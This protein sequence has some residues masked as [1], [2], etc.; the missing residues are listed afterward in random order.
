MIFAVRLDTFPKEAETKVFYVG[1]N[2]PAELTTTR[3]HILAHFADL[4]IEGEYLHRVAFNIAEK[5]GKDAFLSI[6]Y[7]GTGWLPRLFAIK[8]SFDA[9]AARLGFLPRDLSD[10]IMQMMSRLFPI[11]LPKRMKAYR[12]KYEHHL[13]L[14][15]AANGIDDARAFLK[16]IFPSAQGSFFECTK[17]EGDKAFLHRFAAAGAAIRYR[18]IQR[19]EEEDIVALDVA[20]RRNDQDWVEHLPD[21]VA[22]PIIHKLYYGHFFCQVFPQGYIV[23]KGQNTVE[24]EHRMWKLLDARGARYPAEHNV[25]HLYEAKPEL[26]SRY[27]DLDPCNCFNPGIGRA[28]KYV[29]WQQKRPRQSVLRADGRMRRRSATQAP[30]FRRTAIERGV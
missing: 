22:I 3:R 2:D 23:R 18:A 27:R 20:L 17:D 8:G 29:K 9:L 5:Y 4:P 28:S 19:R 1:T 6:Q 16:S 11:H 25:G 13:M 26:V 21:D 24:L 7:L 10:K 30:L 14:K 15:M 12:D